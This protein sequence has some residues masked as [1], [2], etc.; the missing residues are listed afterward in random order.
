M[1]HARIVIV[2]TIVLGQL[3]GLTVALDAWLGGATGQVSWL[4][5]FQ[6]LSFLL[7]LA[8]WLTTPRSLR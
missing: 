8:V 5:A 1:L 2:A 7:A 6:A 3:W 4:L